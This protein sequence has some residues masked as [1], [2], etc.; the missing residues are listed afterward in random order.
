MTHRRKTEWWDTQSNLYSLLALTAYARSVAA[1]SS[2]VI[3]EVA[4]AGAPLI[5]GALAGKQ[6]MRHASVPLPAAATLTISPTG[7]VHYSVEVRH[8]KTLDALKAEAH[9]IQLTSEYFDEAGA[10]KTSFRVGDVVHVKLTAELTVD[11]DHLMLS[12]A[13]PAGFEPL[14]TRFA[15]VGSSVAQTTEWGSYRE[16]RDDRVDFASE[17]RS[18]GRVVHEFQIRAIAAG[19]FTRPPTVAELMYEPA[20]RAQTAADVVEIKARP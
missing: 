14:N 1:S 3:V 17:Y 11:A 8:R 4:G 16:I 10:P 5:A 20:T 9:G 18:R 12:D 2:S 7:E 6:R 13:L 19:K 15:T